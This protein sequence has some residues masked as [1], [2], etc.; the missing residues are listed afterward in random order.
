MES[1]AAS[2]FAAGHIRGVASAPGSRTSCLSRPWE[3]GSRG[4]RSES[5]ETGKWKL[6]V[7]H[8]LSFPR[9]SCSL[10]SFPGC[11]SV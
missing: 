11:D 6:L 9:G 8:D 10:P 5:R 4:T 3:S 1:V 7:V 2:K